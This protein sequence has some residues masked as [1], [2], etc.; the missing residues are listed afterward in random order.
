MSWREFLLIPQLTWYG[1]RAPRD[2][3]KAWDRFWGDVQ[4]TGLEGDVL[5]DAASEAEQ[6]LILERVLS[7]LERSLPVVDVG[8][9]NGR[10]SRV[11]ARHFPRVLGIDAS[12]RAIERARAE[13]AGEGAANLS[14]QVMDGS[15]P[16]AGRELRDTLGEANVF[17]RGVLH[18]LA[19]ATRDAM[20]ASFAE[21]LGRRGTLYLVETNIGHDPLEHLVH[22]GA[23]PTSMPEPL[24][25]CVAA[26]I[27]APS[28]FGDPEV[29][30]HFPDDRWTQ[31]DAGA[32]S[33]H[34]VPLTT[35]TGLEPIPS[36]FAV[37][38]AR[39]RDLAPAAQG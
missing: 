27:R 20:A 34:G 28:H 1:L 16:G 12:P 36:Y 24:R 8:C 5:W 30:R 2:Q 21:V 35:K 26:G 38:R 6:R 3:K 15:A 33:M 13:S 37:L 19:P 7:H 23:T 17:V 10:Y 29:R 14:F 32:V 22:Q 18:V 25:R 31:L 9:G 11:L 39:E 4:K